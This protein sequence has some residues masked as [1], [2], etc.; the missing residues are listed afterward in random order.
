M[1]L[2]QYSIDAFKAD[3]F[4]QDDRGVVWNRRVLD[5]ESKFLFILWVTPTVPLMIYNR[6]VLDGD[7][8]DNWVEV[9][10]CMYYRRTTD[11]EK[12]RNS[13]VWKHAA[14]RMQHMWP[15]SLGLC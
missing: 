13:R 14:E 11:N 12:Y 15:F 8:P 3:D 1:D 4:I 6:D 10:R 5:G 2:E 9:W 7:T